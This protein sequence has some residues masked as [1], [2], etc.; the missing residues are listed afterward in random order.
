MAS[1]LRFCKQ[2]SHLI[3][4]GGILAARFRRLS[5]API[6]AYA[7]AILALLSYIGLGLG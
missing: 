5:D 3:C 7:I 6:S 1:S 2:P 4:R